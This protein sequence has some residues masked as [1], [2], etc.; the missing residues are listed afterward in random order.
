M[1]IKPFAKLKEKLRVSD[2]KSGNP[3][4]DAALKGRI[5]L[6]TIKSNDE[7]IIGWLTMDDKAFDARYNL[8]NKLLGK[9]KTDKYY[10]LWKK[11]GLI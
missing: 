8:K 6:E 11:K 4:S 5:L 10:Q 3:K 2:L 9:L 7:G 1:A